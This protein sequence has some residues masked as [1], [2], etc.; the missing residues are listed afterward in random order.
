[1]RRL[2]AGALVALLWGLT[3]VACGQVTTREAE[4]PDLY[5]HR[6]SPTTQAGGGGGSGGM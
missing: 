6:M 3:L 2:L 4:T 1:M 5:H